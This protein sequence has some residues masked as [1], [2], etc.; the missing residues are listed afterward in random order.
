MVSNDALK[1]LK[2][3]STYLIE[4]LSQAELGMRYL[5]EIKNCQ[6]GNKGTSLLEIQKREWF[7]NEMK[8]LKHEKY[9]EKTLKNYDSEMRKLKIPKDI[10]EG[11]QRMISV[12]SDKTY[13]DIDEIHELY[14]VNKKDEIN[15]DIKDNKVVKMP[16]D[17]FV[18]YCAGFFDAEGSVHIGVDYCLRT[19]ITNTNFDCLKTINE[20]FD[21]YINQL[22]IDEKYKP[23]WLLAFHS[24]GGIPFLKCIESYSIIKGD[25]IRLAIEYQTKV[26]KTPNFAK[27]GLS[28]DEIKIREQYRQKLH[29]LKGQTDESID[30]IDDKN[31]TCKYIKNQ[32][33]H[34]HYWNI[35]YKTT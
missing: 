26:K 13:A 31:D 15:I 30:K 16:D 12:L 14:N 33:V 28:L 23:E 10:R 1:F 20:K 3:I 11:K 18:G 35:E 27:G 8:R 7:R 25:Q 9:N 5:H 2:H 34:D 6:G 4:K 24:E 21:G 17:V 29:K 32:I 22:T 19:K